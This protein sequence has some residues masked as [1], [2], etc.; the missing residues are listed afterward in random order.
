MNNTATSIATHYS[1]SYLQWDHHARWRPHEAGEK[2]N[3]PTGEGPP[4]LM[5][6]VSW[7]HLGDPKDPV[8]LLLSTRAPSITTLQPAS[9][10]GPPYGRG[11]RHHLSHTPVEDKDRAGGF[12]GHLGKYCTWQQTGPMFY[13]QLKLQRIAKVVSHRKL[14]AIASCKPSQKLLAIASCKP[15]KSC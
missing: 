11:D 9:Q 15:S 5:W 14:Q 12:L 4:N 7:G 2:K 3:T 6:A 10:K 1:K 13:A 8:K